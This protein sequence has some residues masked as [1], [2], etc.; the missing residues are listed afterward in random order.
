MQLSPTSSRLSRELQKHGEKQTEQVL[1]LAQFFLVS[2][3]QSRIII[4]SMLLAQ[5]TLGFATYLRH[6]VR[7]R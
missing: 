1:S 5:S 4:K 3:L 6:G 2:I 7:G